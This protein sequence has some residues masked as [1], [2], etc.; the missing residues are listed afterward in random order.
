MPDTAGRTAYRVVQEALT[1]AHTHAPGADV[2][3]TVTGTA[4]SGLAVEVVNS[5]PTD[6]PPAAVAGQGLDGLAE[7][8]DPSGGRLE[9]GPTDAGGW[10]VA[11]WLPLPW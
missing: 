11:A 10:C 2:R 8:V 3:V 6:L 5:A 9:H 1:N 4:D 7:R